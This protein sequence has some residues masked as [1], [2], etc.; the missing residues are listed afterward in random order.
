[1]LRRLLLFLIA[2]DFLLASAS[3]TFQKGL[4]LYLRKEH[5]AAEQMLGEYL[6]A[7]P[8]DKQALYYFAEARAARLQAAHYL[9]RSAF[10][11]EQHR[12]NQAEEML[13]RS[14]AIF[15]GAPGSDALEKEL[16]EQRE[17]SKPL[18]HLSESDRQVHD[19]VIRQGKVEL[20]AGRNARAMEFFSRA[21]ALAP[22]S[23]EALEGFTVAQARYR[24]QLYKDKLYRLF[25]EAERLQKN[26]RIV[27]AL[28]RY[29]E[30]LANDPD[31]MQALGQVRTLEQE[32]AREREMATK[33]KLAEEYLQS[34]NVFLSR[35]LH[36]S[37]IEQYLLGEG[38][39]PEY[40]DWKK[41]ITNANTERE[42]YNR[43]IFEAGLVEI[44]KR[45]QNALFL[46]AKEEFKEA[47]IELDRI[48]AIATQ[49]E[50]RETAAQ[51]NEL[52]RT[53]KENQQLQEEETIT[54][55][56]PY[57]QLVSSLTALGVQS[58]QENNYAAAKQHF[59]AILEIFP[60]NR[61]AN[62]YLLTINVRQQ[63]GAKNKIMADL[64]AEIQLQKTKSI[65]EARRLLALAENIDPDNPAVR[66]LKKE[67]K[68]Q[69]GIQKKTN[70]SKQALDS[71]YQQALRLSQEKP[72]E[73]L[74]LCRQILTEDPT[75]GRCRSLIAG[76][77]GRM[78]R[79]AWERPAPVRSEA[80]QHYARGLLYYNSGNMEAAVESF[81]RA[82]QLE[83]SFEKAKIALQKCQSY[84][85][86]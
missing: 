48:I 71:D 38:I 43:R 15:P 69:T 53:A 68:I 55:E 33:K 66:E 70:R 61:I 59:S 20:A 28:S 5:L 23:T 50:Q 52:L 14:R 42:A 73:A 26:G 67:L 7:H 17:K 2:Q 41:L 31:N 1:M 51:A 63:P 30:I 37:A 47:V 18:E 75:Y 22:K 81:R 19:A 46:M 60:R 85:G 24:E 13:L 74:A 57:Y 10:L 9:V 58:F 77:E 40:T 35:N 34:A 72:A 29:R 78:N 79:Q 64:V 45:F 39:Y 84:L 25:L 36:D 6:S 8:D 65:Q 62:Q 3:D 12:Y 76:I 16:R 86:S 21:L 44:E 56:S 11:M 83:P 27:E 32:I 54:P 4:Q 80:Q 49:Y 82:L